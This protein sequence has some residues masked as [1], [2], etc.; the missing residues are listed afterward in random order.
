MSVRGER[1][2]K[3]LAVEVQELIYRPR[4]QREMTHGLA[5]MHAVNQA[6]LVM[7]RKRGLIG[8]DAAMRLAEAMLALEKEGAAGLPNDPALEDLYF[9]CETAIAARAGGSAGMLHVG[10]SR[11]DIGATIDRMRARH[12][13]IELIDLLNET[14]EALLD[15][16]SRERDT[17]MPGYTHLQP[18]Q[19]VTFGFYLL[20]VATAIAREVTR[21]REEYE[22][23][24]LSPLG[25]GAMAGTSFP[26]DRALTAR[27]LG[28]SG[29]VEHSQ[30]AVASRDYM[31]ALCATCTSLATV[32]S[33]LAQD[34]HVWA[35]PEFGMIELSDAI[36]GVSSIMPQKKNPVVMEALKAQAGE[37]IGDYTAMLAT[38]RGTHFTHS[39]DATRA[40]LNR[41]WASFETCT[42][43][44][45]LLKLLIGSVTPRKARMHDLAATNFSTM[46]DLAEAMAQ[47]GDISFREAHHIV[48]RLVRDASER[49]IA[50]NAI[51]SAMID[52]AAMATTGRAAAFDPQEIA[53]ILDP[54]E[55]V[56]RRVSAGSPA[57]SETARMIAARQK[58]LADDRAGA[59]RMS[60]ALATAREELS[61]AIRALVAKAA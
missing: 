39:I 56:A 33:R 26:I 48:G 22:R 19:P 35:T 21:L 54:A 51:T 5:H 15:A 34:F 27:L 42:T 47:R 9:N 30:D 45:M 18:S 29:V 23:V 16:A 43:S 3:A 44:L 32:W 59:A 12:A 41:A 14:R 38:M 61:H 2:S 4:L 7:L 37:V 53:S 17:V 31:I 52:D 28:F 11:N 36:A 49:N 58:D 57:P 25:A 46:T 24:N 10:R 6:H 50:A 40:S 20:G 1:L 13:T 8:A 55:S 60:L